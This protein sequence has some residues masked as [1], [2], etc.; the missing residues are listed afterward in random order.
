MR[1]EMNGS[2]AWVVLGFLAGA[3]FGRLAIPLFE[4]RTASIVD[5]SDY[6][7]G[8]CAL[9]IADKTSVLGQT[10]GRGEQSTGL[11]C[12]EKWSFGD[13]VIQCRCRR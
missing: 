13:T 1:G 10:T 7:T 2:V 4:P 6:G 3:A 11:K 5:I 8:E 12:D 9:S